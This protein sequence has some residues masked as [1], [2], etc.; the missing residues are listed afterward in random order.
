MTYFKRM[1]SP[2]GELV[3]T[4]DVRGFTGLYLRDKV[5]ESWIEDDA[6]FEEPARQ[7]AA[8]FAGTLTEF[9]LPLVFDGT[10]FQVA[11]WRTLCDIPFGQTISYR[12]LA[13]RVGRPGASRAVGAANGRNPISIIAPCHRVI[14]AD[15][16]LTGYGGGL[17]RKLWLLRHEGVQVPAQAPLIFG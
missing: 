11:V 16:S 13:F 4:A 14:G 3:L 2:I 10:P 9:D 15:G 17:D 5:D 6:P 12:E 1:E 7:L 8:Y